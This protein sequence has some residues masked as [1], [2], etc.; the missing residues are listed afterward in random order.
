MMYGDQRLS[1][2]ELEVIHTPAMQRLYGLKQLGLSDRIYIDASHSRIH[3]VVGVLEQVNNLVNA[4]VINLRRSKRTFEIG[5]VDQ[6]GTIESGPLAQSV[7]SRRP[8]IRFIGLLHDLTHA[9]FGHTVEDEIRIVDSKHDHPDR[10]A[11][12]FYRLLCQLTA[13]ISLE[14]FGPAP[15]AFPMLLRE[16]LSDSTSGAEAPID[17]MV[18]AVKK[19]LEVPAET[20]QRPRLN[21]KQIAEMLTHLRCAMTA[22][23]HLEILHK[24]KPNRKDFPLEGEY[25][26]QE[27]IR[28]AIEGTHFQPLLDEFEFVH[29]R[30]AYMLDI[31][32]NTVCADLLDYAARDSHYAALRLDYDPGRIAEN[33]TLVP[34]DT[35]TYAIEHEEPT[36]ELPPAIKDPFAG[37]CLRTAISLV[38]HKYRSDVPG[39]LMNL[40]NVRFYVYER[41][42]FHPT[43]SAAGS[44]LGT[45]LQL[46]GWRRSDHW[47]FDGLPQHLSFVGDEVFLHDI[48]SALDFLL[49]RLTSRSHDDII[50]DE[51]IQSV[52][53][54]ENVHSGIPFQLL[55]LRCGQKIS[56]ACKE[57][58]ASQLLLNRLSARRYFRPVYRALPS[59][60]D[61]KN[62]GLIADLFQDPNKRYEAER[63]I[64]TGAHL[65]LGAITI[66]CPPLNAARKIANVFLTKPEFDHDGSVIGHRVH[67][68]KHIGKLDEEIFSAHEEAVRAVEKMYASMWRLNVYVAPEHIKDYK[69]IAA[70]AERVVKSRLQR[71]SSFVTLSNDPNLQTELDPRAMSRG[72]GTVDGYDL[73]P[74]GETVGRILDEMVASKEITSI[75]SE[76]YGSA[77]VVPPETRELIR[78]ALR[79]ALSGSGEVRVADTEQMPRPELPSI[80]TANRAARVVTILKT[81]I[82]RPYKTDVEEFEATYLPR[83]E[84][85]PAADFE[86]F[87]SKLVIATERSAEQARLGAKLKAPELMGEAQE[88][89]DLLLNQY[90]TPRS[91][92]PA[93]GDD[94]RG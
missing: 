75:P 29:H 84:A 31:V 70:E 18:V 74:V 72:I 10:Q 9:P 62:A 68:L 37:T 49:R 81:Y 21:P 51:E 20:T 39:E 47:T 78:R 6:M 79:E 88:L 38:S 12:A 56:E 58:A 7:N 91:D 23:V 34:L 61:G 25:P 90:R 89:I 50:S 57:L 43:K 15:D 27:L 45:A 35:A 46:L 13:W 42:I 65:P 19:L 87:C 5:P 40:L 41:V 24:E 26:F 77:E 16:F 66:H 14:A 71:K 54:L 2:A 44:M 64:E 1:A 92:N 33:F 83:F 17:Q 32:G 69:I 76:L 94:D 85:L 82:K 48:R 28:R 52:R 3:H 86:D 4:I 53:D 60:K 63:E 30:D 93:G 80:P 55:T 8:V 22:L 67:K 59:S 11:K 36:K 73:G